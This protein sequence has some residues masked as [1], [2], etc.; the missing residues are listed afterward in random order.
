MAA[1]WRRPAIAV[2]ALIMVVGAAVVLADG[3]GDGDGRAATTTTSSTTSS[4]A[5]PA[6][7]D[8]TGP[9][10]SGTG[11][12]TTSP[13]GPTTSS[14]ATTDPP[15]TAP[16][17][18]AA[19]TTAP[20]PASPATAIRRFDTARRV[21]VLT[22]DAGSDTGYAAEILDRLA[23]NGIRATFGITGRWAEANP[24]LVR[25]MAADGHH[26]VNHSYDHPSFT[27]YSTGAPALGREQRLDQLRRADDA[28]R[29]ATGASTAPWFRPPYGDEDASVRADIALAGY[30]Y[31]LLW[32]VDSLGWKGLAADA[33]V[34][35]CLDGAAPG[36]VYLFHL[37][38]A[39][40]DAAALQRII[41]GLRERGYG[42]ATAAEL[43]A[44]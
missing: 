32:T 42:F 43:A 1:W 25:R 36:A 39:S 15:P 37:G 4:T 41:D 21:V 22:F 29:A 9:V 34:T 23:A 12:P 6:T 44:G 27:G 33:V 35:R 31:E 14:P 20:Q 38:S 24:G 30:R 10:T 2:S 7:T 19:P 3:R 26:L 17:A 16:P 28:I 8:P 40:T 5:A 18:T 11:S 13:P